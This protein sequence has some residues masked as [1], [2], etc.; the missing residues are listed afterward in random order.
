MIRQESKKDPFSSQ[1]NPGHQQSSHS[2]IPHSSCSKPQVINPSTSA[3][4]P[5]P[6]LNP[7]NLKP[8]TLSLKAPNLKPNEPNPKP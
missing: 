6:I 7:R 2:Q 8:E 3:R 4:T 5:N 1:G